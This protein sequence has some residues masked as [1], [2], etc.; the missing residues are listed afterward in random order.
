MP[1]PAADDP[2]LAWAFERGRA[3]VR[4][5]GP[6]VGAG[7]RVEGSAAST[8]LGETATLL[9]RVGGVLPLRAPVRICWTVDTREG[10]GFAYETLRGHPEDGRESF[11]VTRGLGVD[12][13][14]GVWFTV[15]A[16]SKPATWYAR[17]GGP[18]TRMLQHRFANKYLLA[19]AKAAQAR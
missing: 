6:Q 3:L 13:F 15:T 8:S 4:V 12:G 5:W 17:L 16:Y 7:L 14:E 19:V 1:G 18:V 11:V 2:A 10:A 9:V